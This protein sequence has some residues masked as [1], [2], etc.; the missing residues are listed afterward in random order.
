[1]RIAKRN[2]RHPC[3]DAPTTRHKPGRPSH[4]ETHKK[5][6]GQGED[7]FCSCNGC[8]SG[9]ELMTW[10]FKGGRR[11]CWLFVA[12][13]GLFAMQKLVGRKVRACVEDHSLLFVSDPSLDAC[14]RCLAEGSVE[15][16]LVS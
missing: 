7:S 8:C 5:S 13:N 16:A 11:C 14:C 2:N 6:V 15:N 12:A 4:D 1:M 10:A 9:F 3:K